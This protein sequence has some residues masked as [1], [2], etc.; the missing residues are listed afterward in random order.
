MCLKRK[1][2]EEPTVRLFMY[3]GTNIP[4][5]V[6]PEGGVKDSS[7]LLSCERII[8]RLTRYSSLGPIANSGQRALGAP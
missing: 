2:E 8:R 6:S 5:I 4:L 1:E 3:V 7:L